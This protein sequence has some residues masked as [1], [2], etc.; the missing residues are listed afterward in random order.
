MPPIDARLWIAW[1]A[2]IGFAL[3][4]IVGWFIAMEIIAIKNHIPGDTFTELVRS[5]NIPMVVWVIGGATL[6]GAVAGFVLWFPLHIKL[7]W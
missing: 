6:L 5:Q 2:A 3:G 1:L 7:G 4:V